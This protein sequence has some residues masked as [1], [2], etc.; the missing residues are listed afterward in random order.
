MRYFMML[1]NFLFPVYEETGHDGR[2]IRSMLIMLSMV[3]FMS[4]QMWRS[5]FNNFAVEVA[6][7]NAAQ[8]GIIQ[9]VREIPG[10]LAL[11]VIFVIIFIQE[12]YLA[13]LSLALMGL[14]ILLTGFFPDFGGLIFTVLLMSVGFHYFETVNQSLTLQHIPKSETPRFMG[15]IRSYSS[16]GD[17]FG[18]V[19]VLAL[20]TF[21]PYKYIYL[22]AGLLVIAVVAYG[23]WR[24][25]L[26][27]P[28]VVQ[29]KKMILRKRY[30]LYYLLT[31]LSGARRQIFTAF[32]VFLMVQKFGFSVKS[33]TLLFLI[34][35][36]I[37]MFWAP[38]IGR[39]VDQFGER[40]VISI[41]YVGLIFVFAGYA[42]TQSVVVVAALYIFDHLFF[43]MSLAIRTYFQKIADPADI[44]PTMAVGFTINHIAAVVI[45]VTGG[46]IWMIDYR[47]TFLL[48]AFLALAS[49][50][51]AQFVKTP[52]INES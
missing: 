26:F 31:F 35:S 8:M 41:E 32:A 45:P 28:K 22:I 14:G 5:V 51:S 52:A 15:Q 46:L 30:W 12:Q 36:I 34:N 19:A 37:N 24:Y 50:I 3:S 38:L 43:N 11:L 33:I 29:R 4:H 21:L 23:F 39:M 2:Q 49:L 6:G 9:S 7:I 1:R 40:V 48:G 13:F 44:A 27:P 20:L 10:F 16:L 17:I 42:F 47:Y 25:P 18:F